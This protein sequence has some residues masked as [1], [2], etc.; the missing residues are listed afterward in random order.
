MQEQVK[1]WFTMCGIIAVCDVDN[2]IFAR[3]VASLM[4]LQHRGQDSCGIITN[5]GD[6]FFE[7]KALGTVHSVFSEQDFLKGRR[8]IGHTR[9]ATQGQGSVCDAQPL[10]VETNPRIAL[11]QNGNVVNYFELKENLGQEGVSLKTSVDSEVMLH[12]FA[13]EYKK[14][15]DFFAA[16]GSILENVKGGYAIVGLVAG[17]GIFAI[18]DSRGIRPVVLGKK[19]G[20]YMFASETV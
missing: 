11:A 19:Q 7:K 4:S 16:A 17:K 12:V 10:V 13:R 3:T 15:C 8:G 20:S 1:D 5:E 14:R 9:Y 18:R 2:E 6:E